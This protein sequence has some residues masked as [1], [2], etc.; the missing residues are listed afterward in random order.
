MRTPTDEV[1]RHPAQRGHRSQT[2]LCVTPTRGRTVLLWLSLVCAVLSTQTAQAV[3]GLNLSDPDV[4]TANV[5]RLAAKSRAEKAEAIL[6]AQPRGFPV[7][8]EDDRHTCELMALRDGRPLYYATVNVEAATSIA[9]DMIRNVA[10]WDLDGDGLAVGVWDSAGVLADHQEFQEPD[11]RSRVKVRDSLATSGHATHVAGT[12][13][14][15]G[16]DPLAKGMA[17]RAGIESYDWNEDASQMYSRAAMGPGDPGRIYVSNHS[18]GFVAGWDYISSK[19]F[20]GHVGW[21]WF[22]TWAGPNSREDLFGRYTDIAR[23]WDEVA[24][25]HPYYLAFAA[26]GNDRSDNP[27]PGDTVYYWQSTWA[28]IVYSEDTCPLGDAGLQGGYGTISGAAV[29][30]NIITVGAVDEAVSGGIRDLSKAAMAPF[31][32]WGPTD[33]GRIKPDIVANGVGVYST[34]HDSDHD[35]ATNDGTS[36]ACPTATGSAILLVQHHGR[37]FPGGAM[38]SSTLKGLI[39]HTADDLGRPGPDYQYGW[40][41][42]NTRAAAELSRRH[43][44]SLLGDL[45]VQGML[46]GDDPTDTYFFHT[47]GSE[48]IR[49]TICWTDFPA[50][51]TDRHDDPTP[52]LVS[53]LDLRVTGPG[54][55]PTYYP[56]VLDPGDPCAVATAGDNTLDNVE[57][58]YIPAPR[59][60]GIYTVE[61]S[62]AKGGENY[63]LISSVPLH[64]QS[65]PMAENTE[66]YTPLNTPVTIALDATDD[67]RPG[68]LSYSIASLPE[69]GSLEYPDGAQIA[70]PTVLADHHTQ[71]V[72]RPNTD[73]TGD[74]SFTFVVDDGGAAPFGGVSNTATVTIKVRDFVTVKCR[75]GASEDDAY[76]AP[77]YQL[78]S[79]RHLWVSQYTS[80]MR[81][82]GVEVPAGSEIISAHLKLFHQSTRT[83]KYP[84]ESVVWAEATG[85]A[86]DFTGGQPMVERPKT[87]ATVLWAWEVGAYLIGGWYTSP[88][89]GQVIQEVVNRSDWSQGNAV[90]VMYGGQSGSQSLYFNS[91]DNNP[92]NAPRLEITY[93]R[94]TASGT[95]PGPVTAVDAVERP[96]TAQDAQIYLSS[97]QSATTPLEATDNEL[98]DPPGVRAAAL[99]EHGSPVA[100]T[101]DAELAGRSSFTFS[102]DGRIVLSGPVPNRATMTTAAAPSADEMV[103]RKFYV[104]TPEDDASGSNG[105]EPVLSP[106]L[107]FGPEGSGMRFRNIDIPNGSVI[108]SAHLRLCMDTAQ[109][110]RPIDGLVRAE[111]TGNALDFAQGNPGVDERLKTEASVPWVWEA[112]NIEQGTWHTSPDIADVIQEVVDRQDWWSGHS[113]AIFCSGNDA[114]LQFH[115]C[116]YKYFDLAAQ[117]EITFIPNP[118]PDV[119]PPEPEQ[120]PPTT[121]DLEVEAPFNTPVTIT[122]KASD[123][124]LPDPP[125][126]LSYTVASL[127]SHGTLEDPDGAL[128][129][130]PLTL[131]DFRNQVVYRPNVGFSGQDS[132]TFYADDGGTAPSGGASNTATVTITVTETLPPSPMAYWPFDEGEGQTAYDSVGDRH[133][134]LNG[135]EWTDGVIGGALAFDGKWDSASLPLNEPVW[136]PQSDFAIAFWVY[137]ETRG[138]G[139]PPSEFEFILDL[140]YAVSQNT[141]NELGYGIYRHLESQ[142]IVFGMITSEKSEEDLFTDTQFVEGQWYHIVAVRNGTSQELYVDGEL[143]CD[144]TCSAAPIAFTGDYDDN[145]VNVGQYTIRNGPTGF[146]FKGKLDELT[147]FY[148]ALS[149]HEVRRI[150]GQ[151]TAGPHVPPTAEDTRVTTSFNSPAPITLKASDD[152]QPNPPGKLTY[153]LASLTAHGALEYPSGGQILQPT[154]LPNYGNQVVYRPDPEFGGEDTFTF[155]ADDG[156]NAP[157]GGAS[158]TATV[159]IVVKENALPDPIGHWSFDEGQGE[160]A[161]DSAGGR[162]GTVYGAEWT[163]GMVGGA[164]DFDGVSDYVALPKN[165]P[166]W[167]PGNDFTLAFW[168]YFATDYAAENEVILDLNHAASSN[169][170]NELGY[171]VLRRPFAGEIVFQMTTMENSDEELYTQTRFDKGKWHHVAAVRDGGRQEIYVDGES[172]K[173]RPCSRTSIKFVGGYDDDDINV[174]RYTSLGG[175]PRYHLRGKV[176]EIMIFD[177]ALSADEIRHIHD[178]AAR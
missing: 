51:W 156:G 122:L 56:Y 58:V 77:G 86:A 87:E 54:G 29:A 111:A 7:R 37:L 47:D 176:D 18:Y 65:A 35:Y 109:I 75:V 162:H 64:D 145:K 41:L 160:T 146:R 124:G 142:T 52:R 67:G 137:F 17:P 136:L 22:G 36:M 81:F 163:E 123:E 149:A 90:V 45:I 42:M 14:A 19:Y 159:T 99:A 70:V 120:S 103:T 13:G 15:A 50:K 106:M 102:H 97:Y 53:D 61:V 2:D 127:P 129:D 48:P 166:V 49:I 33:D 157:G 133:A 118:N 132:F 79:G 164:L 85:N 95:G 46:N 178:A 59:E 12:I 101:R 80:A 128:I 78:A 62:L 55:S 155:W 161:Y 153:V 83:V 34:D 9:T 69:H 21:H 89:I 93:A 173:T 100:D 135:V 44:D 105:D 104:L 39:I 16:V 115:A 74:D 131:V 94:G 27:E 40:G 6:W 68:P 112:G 4:H 32:N 113:L 130:Q 148:E 98:P 147:I 3:Q 151:T 110:D 72:Y 11:G 170:Y 126:V 73:F 20:S 174:A 84:V 23:D 25:M 24:H 140:N 82:R 43:H 116:A 91:W 138:A 154:P 71:M 171:C 92:D 31:G 117:I 141:Y 134:A 96:P 88:N 60:Q 57:Q 158:N 121:E 175:S 107:S 152:G 143:D 177:E 108:V 66:V 26:A 63:S 38:R 10:P 114:N 139:S 125:G 150:Y 167:L 165:H 1:L 28:S 5:Q 168:V 169:P 119:E 8:Y 172:E 30:K 144:R 76:G